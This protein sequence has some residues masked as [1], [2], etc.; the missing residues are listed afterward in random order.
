MFFIPDLSL[1]GITMKNKAG[2]FIYNLFHHKGVAI[3]VW[4]VGLYMGIS[5]M[6]LA[7]LILFGHSSFDRFLGFD[8]QTRTEL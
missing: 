8:L 4:I 1:A 2:L 5:Y 6:T 3:T 7:G